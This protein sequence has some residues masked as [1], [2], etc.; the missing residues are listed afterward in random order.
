MITVYYFLHNSILVKTTH[1]NEPAPLLLKQYNNLLKNSYIVVQS[2][3]GLSS[4][5]VIK[6]YTITDKETLR[7]T[8]NVY[9]D[10]LYASIPDVTPI[11]TA[12]KDYLEFMSNFKRCFSHFL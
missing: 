7:I 4:F 1:V 9:D 12:S 2:N 8:A 3:S 10:I 6:E 11:A 5:S